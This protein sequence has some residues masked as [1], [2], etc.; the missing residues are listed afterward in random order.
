MLPAK[1]KDEN[2]RRKLF[3]K[4]FERIKESKGGNLINPCESNILEI[5]GPYFL[6]DRSNELARTFESK[7][8]TKIKIT[9]H[10]DMANGYIWE[11]I[12]LI[13]AC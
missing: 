1:E 9:R 12:S 11:G 2:R 3:W 5:Q 10:R 13:N 8:H 4:V 6:Y 7:N